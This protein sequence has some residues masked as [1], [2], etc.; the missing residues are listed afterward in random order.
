MAP[1]YFDRLVVGDPVKPWPQVDLA[2]LAGERPKRLE[3]RVLQGVLGVLGFAQNPD[4]EPVE[5]LL[6]AAKYRG[7]R[8]EVSALR[9]P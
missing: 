4:A 2:L 6:V 5:V 8:I 9:P 7:K 1:P 3:H